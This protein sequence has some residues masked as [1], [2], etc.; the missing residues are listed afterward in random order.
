MLQEY[1]WCYSN[2]II[3]ECFEWLFFIDDTSV[4]KIY[5]V[6]ITSLLGVYQFY[7]LVRIN[8]RF[9]IKNYNIKNKLNTPILLQ[10][11]FYCNR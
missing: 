1:N 4:Y 3:K 8:N 9:E 6:S 11:K 2:N 5:V 7:Q 10:N